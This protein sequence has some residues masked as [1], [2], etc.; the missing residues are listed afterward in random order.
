MKYEQ[1]TSPAEAGSSSV[2]I[3]IG[4]GLFEVLASVSAGLTTDRMQP[5]RIYFQKTLA[6]ETTLNQDLVSGEFT[7]LLP[8]SMIESKLVQGPG[9]IYTSI[10]HLDTTSHTLVI[11]YRRVEELL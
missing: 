10:F 11:G 6:D 2:S 5:A 4:E 3:P 9:R 1:K 8:L 7:P